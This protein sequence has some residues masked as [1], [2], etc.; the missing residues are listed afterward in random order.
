MASS[1]PVHTDHGPVEGGV[2][3]AVVTAECGE[4]KEDECRA[5]LRQGG[6]EVD[7]DALI[8]VSSRP[9]HGRRRMVGTAVEYVSAPSSGGEGTR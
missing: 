3:F 6:C 7:A 8:D 4:S 5:Q 1:L 9:A 2:A